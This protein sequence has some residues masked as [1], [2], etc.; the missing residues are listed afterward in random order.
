MTNP[1]SQYLSL[2]RGC[3]ET[4]VEFATDRYG[5]VHTPLLVSI[6]DVETRHCPADPDPL[7]EHY[8][9]T[10]RGRRS[11]G[12]SNLLTDQPLI[13]AMVALS[14][15]TGDDTYETCAERYAAYVM[16]HL[17]DERGLFWWGWHRHY[18]VHRDVMDGHNGSPHEIHAIHAIDWDFLGKVDAAAVRREI[19][20]IWQ[21]HVI[22]KATGEV[23]RHGDGRRGCDFSMSAGAC[24]EAFAFLHGQTA[25]P[26][27]LER[28]GL[29]ADYYWHRRNPATD[30]VPDRPNAGRDRF[31]G[32]SFLTSTTGL[33]CHSLLR[34][35]EMTGAAVF[36]DYAAAY[37]KAYAHY[38]YD[39][40]SG[41]FWGALRMNG[42]PVGGPRVYTDR[43][44]SADGYAASQPRGHLDLW[45]PYVAGYQHPIFTA[46]AYVHAYHLT[47]A[48]ELLTA[49]RRFAAWIARTPPGTVETDTAWYR[50]WSRGPGRQGTYADKYARTVSFLLHL[51]VVTAE[52]PFLDDARAM[53]A[54]AVARLHH[55]GLFRG[56]PAKPYYEAVDGV[57]RLLYALVQLDGVL[58]DPGGAVG[59]R[60]ILLGPRRV[61]LS[62]ENW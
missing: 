38:G 28:A 13:R 30:L 59:A 35:Y 24:I 9:V 41:R 47:G 51:F 7:D 3:I 42:T 32:C 33:H 22:D 61:A 31:D 20:A 5:P 53:A 52:W 21:W 17:V 23:N 36:R 12:G 39:A 37:L 19:E 29:L 10:R 16:R 46:Q 57:G 34:A 26:V 25:D 62:L 11:P 14:A 48:P 1:D 45:G 50:D 54:E 8:R 58:A 40:G 18:D 4:L 49:A 27:W 55:E 43:L 15:V 44:D 2:V 6:L 56:H 60:R